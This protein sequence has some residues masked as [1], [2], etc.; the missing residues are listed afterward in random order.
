L[1]FLRD[2]PHSHAQEWTRFRGPNG[3][4]ISNAKTIPSQWREKDINWKV[5]LPG[6]GQ[7]SPVIWGGKVFLTSA[8]EKSP[9]LHLFCIEAGRGRKLW[10]KDFDLLPYPLHQFNTFASA[11][12]AADGQHVYLAWLTQGHYH[13]T[14]FDHEDGQQDWDRDLGTFESQHGSGASPTVYGD[15]VIVTKA[16][17]GKSFLISVDSRTGQTR[18]QTPLRCTRADYSTVCVAE[19]FGSKP[20]LIF[21]GMEDGV[22]AFDAQT[23]A[24]VWRLDKVFSQRC[25]SSPVLG[26]ELIIGSC[27]SGA[28]GNYVAAVRVA[29]LEHG[30]KPELAYVA[31]KSA[32]YVPTSLVLGDLLFLWSDGGIVSC[33]DALRGDVLWQERVGGNFFASPICVDGRL[34]NVSLSGEVIVLKAAKEFQELARNSLGEGTRATPSVSDGRMYLRTFSHLISVGGSD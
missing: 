25:V 28:G 16:P 26:P 24:L 9:K 10:Q 31:K 27:G 5:E 7:S 19:N 1:I 32:P 30:G 20:L 13:L 21:T 18:W 34:F 17:D 6:I 22:S 29:D 8:D 14:A 15:S 4:G 23:G 3:T 11:T 12:P 2:L 33:L